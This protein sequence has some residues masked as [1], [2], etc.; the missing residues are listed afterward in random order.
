MPYRDTV[1]AR[2]TSSPSTGLGRDR[3]SRANRDTAPPIHPTVEDP[4]EP[5]MTRHPALAHAE[6]SDAARP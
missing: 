2:C 3:D 6:A 1:T 4:N 5:L